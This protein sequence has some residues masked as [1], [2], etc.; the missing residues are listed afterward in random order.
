MKYPPEAD[1]CL[2]I[3]TDDEFFNDLSEE[4]VIPSFKKYTENIISKEEANEELS[5][6]E[7]DFKT[8]MRIEEM[9]YMKKPKAKDK[10]DS[11]SF[12]KFFDKKKNVFKTVKK[13]WWHEE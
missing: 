12:I 2:N 9:K 13:S 8:L 4:Y 5:K 7:K 11:C 10:K 1:D 3:S 6:N